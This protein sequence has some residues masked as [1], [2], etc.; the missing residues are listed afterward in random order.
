MKKPTL[1]DP[2][3]TFRANLSELQKQCQGL[4]FLP[5]CLSVSNIW[6]CSVS[7]GAWGKQR[8]QQITQAHQFDAAGCR[9][10]HDDFVPLL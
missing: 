7:K 6:G 9:Y 3:D 8:S 5:L 10:L 1:L 4:R 2:G